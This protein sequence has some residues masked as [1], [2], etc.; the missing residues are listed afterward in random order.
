MKVSGPLAALGLAVLLVHVV[1]AS[2]VPMMPA[3]T[4]SP[5]PAITPPDAA[6]VAFRKAPAPRPL[7]AGVIARISFAKG[8]SDITRRQFLEAARQLE[9]QPGSLTPEVSGQVLDLLLQKRV[10]SHRAKT[11][12]RRWR[13]PDSL[14]YN[15][16]FD[17]L[18]LTAALDSAMADLRAKLLLHSDSVPDPQTLGIMLRD[19]AM[20][21]LAPQYDEGALALVAKVFADMPKA[22]AK[23]GMQEQIKLRLAM[24][25]VS[26]ADSAR[27]LIRSSLGTYTVGKLLEEFGRLNPS[28]RP[29]VTSADDVRDVAN[30]VIYEALL[31]KRIAQQHIER[32]PAIAAQLADKAEFLDVQVFV[33]HAAYEQVPTDSVTVR[34]HFDAHPRWFDSWAR[35]EIVRAIFPAEASADSF[36][37]ALHV[38]GAA[39]S[40]VTRKMPSGLPYFTHLVESADTSLFARIERAGVKGV[41]GPEESIDGWRVVCALK[42]EPRAPRTFE[43][44]H[45]T[46]LN[47]WYQRDGDRRVREMMASLAASVQVQV[48]EP[49]LAAAAKAFA[50]PAAGAPAPGAA[51][52]SR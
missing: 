4:E 34:R 15:R 21:Q 22:T 46:V 18:T 19:S 33:R 5:T 29:A 11:D 28:Y 30:S 8:T 20:A 43:Q 50:V 38:P 32:R 37:K 26:R 51:V 7:P 47:D 3:G 27:M 35:A 23:M 6:G 48:N 52:R 24:P 42:I 10:L 39:E 16:L 9:L 13:H 36:A 41:V 31:H 1:A 2:P 17:R 14:E 44:A 40:L 12:P 25:S 49:G 45:D